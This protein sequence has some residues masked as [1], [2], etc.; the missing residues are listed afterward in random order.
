M[1]QAENVPGGVNV[2]VMNDTATHARPFSYTQVF[3]AF[4]TAERSAL[5]TNLSRESFIHFHVPGPVRNRFI[6]EHVAEGRP[7]GVAHGLCESSAAQACGG[8]VSNSNEVVTADEV[9]ARLVQEVPSLICDLGVD[10]AGL[11]LAAGT[12]GLPEAL[13]GLSVDLWRGNRLAVRCGG[14]S[15]QAEVYANGP[16]RSPRLRLGH[17]H[18]EVQVPAPASVGRKAGAVHDLAA[19]GYRAGHPNVVVGATEAQ[20]VRES[21]AG[22]GPDRNPAEAAPATV[23]QPTT[24]ALPQGPSVLLADGADRAAAEPE[25]LG[26]ADRQLLD[27]ECARPSVSALN[28]CLLGVPTKVPHEIDSPRHAVQLRSVLVFNA[29]SEGEMQHL[30]ISRHARGNRVSKE[31]APKTEPMSE[32]E[33]KY[34]VIYQNRRGPFKGQIRMEHV[35]T[36]DPRGYLDPGEYEL[37]LILHGWP[38]THWCAR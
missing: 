19:V 8:N 34:T 10:G 28:G 17:F 36:D 37:Y 24:M 33:R 32:R 27:G 9:S 5:G 1:S 11:A 18:D 31:S 7:A 35:R 15:L 38:K 22:V 21:P 2:A 6:A 29:V 14:Q 16:R 26:C 20:A 4:R 3:S 25:G 12:L 30:I 23:T 13:L